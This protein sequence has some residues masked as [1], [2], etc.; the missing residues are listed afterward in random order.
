MNQIIMPRKYLIAFIITNLVLFS[1]A[2]GADVVVLKTGKKFEV[3]K[4]W[5]E[6]DQIWIIFHGMRAKIPTNKVKRIETKSNPHYGKPLIQDALS[7]D[8]KPKTVSTPPNT[9]RHQPEH[10]VQTPSAPTAGSLNTDKVNADKELIFPD[11]SLGNLKW[12]TRINALKGLE[13]IQDTKGPDDVVEYR[14]KSKNLELGQAALSSID[15]AFWRDRLYMLTIRTRGHSNYIAL[16]SEVFRQ[17]GH[18]R[19]ADQPYERYLWTEAPS[20]IMLEYSQDDEQGLLWL[21]SNEIDR[22]YKLSRMSG[23]ASYLKWMKSRN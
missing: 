3:E 1:F 17:F 14:L 23:H 7:R 10:A 15:Y 16:R 20:D 12:G 5:R 21:R 11:K 22:Q 2:A 18:G 13:K 6:N 19:R 4:A 9:A 8:L